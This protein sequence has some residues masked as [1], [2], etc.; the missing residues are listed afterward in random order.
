MTDIVPGAAL[1]ALLSPG[2]FFQ[3]VQKMKYRLLPSIDDVQLW[4]TSDLFMP[5]KCLLW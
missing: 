1:K 2:A 4:P 5:D 3:L